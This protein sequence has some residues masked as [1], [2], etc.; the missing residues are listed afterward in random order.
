MPSAEIMLHNKD[1]EE[2]PISNNTIQ[3]RILNMPDNIQDSVIAKEKRSF[4]LN[5]SMNLLTS[6]IMHN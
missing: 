5:K 4:S 3:G 2:I 1:E 6:V